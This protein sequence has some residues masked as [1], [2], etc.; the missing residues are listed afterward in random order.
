MS[1]KV[2][3]YKDIAIANFADSLKYHNIFERLED[4]DIFLRKVGISELINEY[5]YYLSKTVSNGKYINPNPNENFVY[6]LMGLMKKISSNEEV[7]YRFILELTKKLESRFYIDSDYVLKEENIEILES[8]KRNLAILGYEFSYEY[9]KDPLH[10]EE[11]VHFKIRILSDGVLN[12]DEDISF[13]IGAMKTYNVGIYESYKEAI[14][15]YSNGNYASCIRTCREVFENIFKKHST[16]NK[17]DE[18]ILNF[19]GEK[20]PNGTEIT[21]RATQT[22]IF[23]YS[24][25]VGRFKERGEGFDFYK[26]LIT[27][28][29]FMS[30][31]GGHKSEDVEITDIES[32]FCLR[33]LEDILIWHYQTKGKVNKGL[34]G[35]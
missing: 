26:L 21:P 12:R 6:G 13:V 32:L 1:F 24:L 20:V 22:D 31:K 33:I 2:D 9:K 28:Y 34:R 3:N 14:S 10:N 27:F 16:K 5:K 23:Q 11:D 17:Y 7:F 30:S 4:V 18:G 25:G 19:T 8:M 15:N 35:H 29:S